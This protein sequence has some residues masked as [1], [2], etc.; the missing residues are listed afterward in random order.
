MTESSDHKARK[1]QERQALSFPLAA[2]QATEK[3]TG[4]MVRV[5]DGILQ[6]R[7][8]MPMALAHINVYLLRDDDGWW[9][10]DTGLDTEASKLC[11]Q[12][13]AANTEALE[14][15]PFKGVI[16]THFHHDHTGMADWL[17]AQFDIPLYMS[18]GEYLI[19]RT[20][21]RSNE[22]GLSQAQMDFYRMAGVPEK[23]LTALREDFGRIQMSLQCPESFHRLRDGQTLTI[24]DRAWEV[25]IG[26]GHAPEHVCL[27]SAVD[28]LLVA[29]DQ[30]LPDI[31]PNIMVGHIEPEADPMSDWFASLDRLSQ[32]DA[33]TLVMPA[34]GDVF[35]NLHQRV[36]Q[37]RQHHERQFDHLRSL[38][39]TNNRLTTFEAMRE[40]FPQALDSVQLML[41]LGETLAHLT[42]LR[43]HGD[44]VRAFDD[45]VY[46]YSG[47]HE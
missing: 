30:I 16:C 28:K 5:T 45:G 39:E 21:A 41:A 1:Q 37:L 13:I 36:A 22:D 27:Y 3:T 25:V 38:A 9:L 11:W 47:R 35:L 20:L 44:L 46:L 24:G 19:F 17:T 14:G 40:L 8:P 15:L 2:P 7:I 32:L 26:E 10:V 42:W 4:D 6:A 12:R 31:S 33:D 23:R 18:H 43:G 29:G 34:H